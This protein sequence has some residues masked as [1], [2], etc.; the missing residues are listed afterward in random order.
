MKRTVRGGRVYRSDGTI[1]NDADGIDA[2]GRRI[3]VIAE[4][5]NEYF[6]VEGESPPIENVP[7]GASGM[8][9]TTRDIYIF[10]GTAW[11]VF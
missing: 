6:W 2:E 1:A 11:E 5:Q 9:I 10:N 4:N 3:V 7:R 8:N